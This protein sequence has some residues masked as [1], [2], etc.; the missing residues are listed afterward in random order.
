MIDPRSALVEIKRLPEAKDFMRMELAKSRKLLKSGPEQLAR[1]HLVAN[2]L[3][4]L[5]E[6]QEAFEEN[7]TLLESLDFTSKSA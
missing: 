2:L 7:Q 5:G 4:E 3:F 6:W 1:R